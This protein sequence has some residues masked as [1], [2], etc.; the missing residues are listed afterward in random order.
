M[1]GLALQP[2]KEMLKAKNKKNVAKAM[3]PAQIA[4]AQKLSR[5]LWEKYVVPF[6]KE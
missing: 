1:P 3:T 4:E 2:R 5:E 6:R